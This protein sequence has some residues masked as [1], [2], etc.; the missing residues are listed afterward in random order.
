[1]NRQKF[2]QTIPYLILGMFTLFFCWFFC[3]RYGVF[4]S[5]VDWISQHSVLP[6]YFRQQF[7][8]TDSYFRSLQQI[9]E[10]GKI[11]ITL[12]IMVC[13]ALLF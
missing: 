2:K 10:E 6:D 11:F 3:G 13:I 8:N 4:G 12:P 9:S 1:M 7:Y 5:K